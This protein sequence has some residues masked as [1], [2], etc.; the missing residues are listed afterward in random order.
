MWPVYPS[1]EVL[2]GQSPDSFA[3]CAKPDFDLI[4][5]LSPLTTLFLL[6][7]RK[8]LKNKP[9]WFSREMTDFF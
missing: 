7:F 4:I 6:K 1:R 9:C 3:S 5:I 8:E 2:Q